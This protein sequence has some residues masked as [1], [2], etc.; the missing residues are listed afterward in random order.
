MREMKLKEA[1]GPTLGRPWVTPWVG[2]QRQTVP[3]S[4]QIAPGTPLH[5]TQVFPDS[6]AYVKLYCVMYQTNISLSGILKE[7][8][9]LSVGIIR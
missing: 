6:P 1:P 4:P 3:G 2:F 9:A 5:R 7:I 8:L